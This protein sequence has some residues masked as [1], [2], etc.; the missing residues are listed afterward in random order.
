[1][2]SAN[3]DELETRRGLPAP[4]A[5]GRDLSGTSS[6]ASSSLTRLLE[7]RVAQRSGHDPP[8]PLPV[9]EKKP[10][11]PLDSEGEEA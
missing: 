9:W 7:M 8:S 4:A 11:S 5:A 2:G 3:S 1:M 6:E 10:G